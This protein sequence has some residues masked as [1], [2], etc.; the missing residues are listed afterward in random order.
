MNKKKLPKS[1]PEVKKIMSTRMYYSGE[2]I[3]L[4]GIL[5]LFWVFKDFNLSNPEFSNSLPINSIICFIL[6]V[7]GSIIRTKAKNE[8][9]VLFNQ[10][11]MKKNIS[12]KKIRYRQ[13][14]HR[15]SFRK[16]S[17]KNY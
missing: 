3:M 4:S 5:P 10:T 9:N 6:L 8:L 2:Y 13:I 14:K 17:I 1:H 7:V 16:K 11:D 15:K 12:K